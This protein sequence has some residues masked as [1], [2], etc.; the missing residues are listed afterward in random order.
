[1]SL[2]IRIYFSTSN[3]SWIITNSCSFLSYESI[4]LLLPLRFLLFNLKNLTRCIQHK[5]FIQVSTEISV[6]DFYLLCLIFCVNPMFKI[7][8][9]VSWGSPKKGRNLNEEIILASVL[10]PKLN[11]SLE[12][13]DRFHLFL[14]V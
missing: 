9:I 11:Q 2:P 10:W 13:L 5:Y 7:V 14:S 3:A 8:S 12:A 6:S 4:F 1:M